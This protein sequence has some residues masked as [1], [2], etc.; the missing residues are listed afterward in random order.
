MER[1]KARN[2][3]KAGSA[4]SVGERISSRARGSQEDAPSGDEQRVRAYASELATAAGTEKEFSRN[5][6]NVIEAS[7]LHS[8]PST[9]APNHT[10]APLSIGLVS[11]SSSPAANSNSLVKRRFSTNES[12]G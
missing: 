5:A 4:S 11:R 12:V 2:R 3:F 7:A 9:I 1:I 8:A 6:G 10:N